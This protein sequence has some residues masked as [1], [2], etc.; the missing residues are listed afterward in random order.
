MAAG[1][2]FSPSSYNSN[3]AKFLPSIRD[4]I[5]SDPSLTSLRNRLRWEEYR[6]TDPLAVFVTT[7]NAGGTKR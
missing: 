3:E 1:S 4:Q 7:W 6:A 2:G 5:D